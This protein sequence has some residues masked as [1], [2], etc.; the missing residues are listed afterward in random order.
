M[1]PTIGIDFDNTIVCCDALFYDVARSLRFVPDSIEKTKSAVRKYTQTHLSNEHWTILQAEVYGTRLS[2]AE[3]YPGVIDF[4]IDCRKHAISTSI[5]SHK[6]RYPRLGKR[7]DLHQAALEWLS[8]N[9]FFSN[10]IINL[11]QDRVV[12][13]LTRQEKIQKVFQQRCT[14]FIDD[15]PEVFSATDFPAGVE[16]ILFD[17]HNTYKH[18][19]GGIRV[20]SWDEIRK[21]FFSDALCRGH[22][23]L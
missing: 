12:F 8:Q 9:G 11:S 18:W 5:I 17:A 19:N 7:Y 22:R 2:G 14:H 3:P 4:F 16:R 10:D 20:F 15:L 6:T 21:T 23:G 13:A 1:H